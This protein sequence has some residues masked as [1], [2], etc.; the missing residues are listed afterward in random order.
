MVTIPIRNTIK[1]FYAIE[2]LNITTL[3]KLQGKVTVDYYLSLTT[4]LSAKY[5]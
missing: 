3:G 4:S 1:M 2:F 5:F